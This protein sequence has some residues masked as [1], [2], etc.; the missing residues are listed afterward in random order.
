MTLGVLWRALRARPEVFPVAQLLRE[1]V[2]LI[3]GA[4]QGIG[5]AI[6]TACAAEGAMV[7]AADLA[8]PH[9]TVQDLER[10]G[11]KGVAF[12]CDVRDALAVDATVAAVEAAFGQIDV[13]V[14]NAGVSGQTG[15][16]ETI[17]P[18]AFDEV[19]AVN[20]RGP[21]LL[22]RAV[23]PGMKRRQFGRIINI[24]SIAGKEPSPEYAP[25]CATKMGLIGLT[26]TL[27]KEV[28]RFG[29]TANSIC[30]GV[31]DSGQRYQNVLIGRA[32][33]A[34]VTP[35]EIQES[36]IAQTAIGRIIHPQD[37]ARAV[38]FLASDAAAAI[39]GEDLNVTGGAVMY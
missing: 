39:T 25:Y 35:Q 15:P 29:I 5:R 37:V 28:G 38:V 1:R 34:G 21:Y 17:P 30:P 36:L 33:A 6:A 31:T 26:R 7:A 18:E 10:L 11:G 9:P 14:N 20:L 19:V 3:T 2:V 4:G 24:A 23:L 32:R 8:P 12:P 13:L 22:C 27:A 16:L